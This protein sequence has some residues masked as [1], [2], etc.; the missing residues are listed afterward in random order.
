MNFDENWRRGGRSGSGGRRP[1]PPRLPGCPSCCRAGDACLAVIG[2]PDPP[3]WTTGDVRSVRCLWLPDAAGLNAVVDAP[4]LRGLVLRG[5]GLGGPVTVVEPSPPTP[6]CQDVTLA[7]TAGVG[8]PVLLA[9]PANVRRPDASLR[10]LLVRWGSAGRIPR[11]GPRG[12]LVRRAASG[13]QMSPDRSPWRWPGHLRARS[14]A[15]LTARLPRWSP[16][17]PWTPACQNVT[18][19]C[20]AGVRAPVL[21]ARPADD[22]W[23]PV[24]LRG[25]LV[26]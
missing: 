18:P 8:A 26:R 1:R 21:L 14:L 17:C 6:A 12:M 16:R 19:A 2:R 3:L 5:R 13:F 9:R 4:S 20:A 7:G 10:G 15:G 11:R 25:L 23:R 22:V 24:L